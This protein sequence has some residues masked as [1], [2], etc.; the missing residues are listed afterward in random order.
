M[1]FTTFHPT[2]DRGNKYIIMAIDYFT[3]WVDAIA[4]FSNDGGTITLFKFNKVITRFRV[5]REIVTN[6]E[7]HFQN[8]IM[9]ELTLKVVLKKEH[10]SPYYPQANGQVESVNKSLKTILQ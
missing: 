4:M 3:K 5:L 8:N 7:S 10:L 1:D 6:H 2:L 9:L